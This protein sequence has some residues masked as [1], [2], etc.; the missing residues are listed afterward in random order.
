M[1]T[2][3]IDSGWE[4]GTVTFDDSREV[5]DKVFDA[6]IENFYMRFCS[7]HGES[8]MQ[9]DEPQIHAPEV[10][11]DIADEILKFDVRYEGEDDE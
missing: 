1:R 4:R 2:L 5:R 10:L 7:F 8:I 9:G 3:D 11:A 6:L